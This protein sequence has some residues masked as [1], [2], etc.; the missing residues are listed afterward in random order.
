ML[1][2]KGGDKAVLSGKFWSW[3]SP[4]LESYARKT[5]I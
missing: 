4:E 2:L 3:N 1:S 5:A